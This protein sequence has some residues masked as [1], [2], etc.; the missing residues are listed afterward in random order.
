M[1][2]VIM[3]RGW[4]FDW[5]NGPMRTD[6]EPDRPSED[7]DQRWWQQQDEERQRQEEE[8]CQR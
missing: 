4:Q 8:Q 2:D 6:Y 5:V 1:R 7:D 3:P